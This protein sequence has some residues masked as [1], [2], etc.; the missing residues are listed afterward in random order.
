MRSSS[1][2]QRILVTSTALLC[3][4]DI[5]AGDQHPDGLP[6]EVVTLRDGRRLSGHYDPFNAILWLDGPYRARLRLQHGDVIRRTPIA[7]PQP[8]RVAD[9]PIIG[10]STASM[11]TAQRAQTLRLREQQVADLDRRKQ[12]TSDSIRLLTSTLDTLDETNRGLDLARSTQPENSPKT[13][14][15]AAQQRKIQLQIND[16]RRRLSMLNEQATLLSK[17]REQIAALVAR[18]R[19][20]PSG[21]A[22][23]QV[24]LS[25][26]PPD[27][28]FEMRLR[29]L[30]DE[31]RALRAD[32]VE[33]HRLL[34]E[35][36]K[37]AS[38]PA[39]ETLP[40]IEPPDNPTPAPAPAVQP[41][42][43]EPTA[44]PEPTVEITTNEQ[45]AR[46]V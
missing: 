6:H 12:E 28:M 36:T 34:D 14:T 16:I 31:V 46:G 2:L 20:A 18:A 9:K 1:W 43:A 33:L 32:N 40:V 42:P 27:P 26:L 44:V 25:D 10:A 3:L 38:P 24:A 19:S 5:T 11:I 13:E 41:T 30:E 22:A 37:A 17:R 15:L 8:S 21:T 23:E 7:D 39:S 45:V 4:S 35:L 29:V